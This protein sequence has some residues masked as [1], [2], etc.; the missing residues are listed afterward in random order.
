M[1]SGGPERESI[2]AVGA[3]PAAQAM[4]SLQLV[5]VCITLNTLFKI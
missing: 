3:N 4:T 1:N 2:T 5:T